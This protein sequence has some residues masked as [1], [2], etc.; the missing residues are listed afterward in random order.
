MN[1]KWLARN[2]RRAEAA[3]ARAETAEVGN[4]RLLVDLER[5][6]REIARMDE[7]HA[8]IRAELARAY[9]TIDRMGDVL[10]MHGRERRHLESVPTVA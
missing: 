8:E 10:V 2:K 3:E 7:Q 5:A 6:E 1:I 4:A 9:D